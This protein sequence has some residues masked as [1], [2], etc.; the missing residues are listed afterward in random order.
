[1][2]EQKC[3]VCGDS[4]Q[5][6][7]PLSP[8]IGQ[9]CPQ[10]VEEF[11]AQEEPPQ[12]PKG[13]QGSKDE[14]DLPLP[15]RTNDELR[16]ELAVLQYCVRQLRERAKSDSTHAWL[17]K[18][19][20][21]VAVGCM[22]LIRTTLSEDIGSLPALSQEQQ[23]EI[24][25]EHPLLDNTRLPREPFCHEHSEWFREIRKKALDYA[26]RIDF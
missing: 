21:K 3:Q 2:N 5:G 6:K 19:K 1:M 25:R 11:D 15:G 4:F 26:R 17:W 18:L 20:A 14:V 23:D 16:G 24:Q 8:F 9:I 10:C 13:P 12:P 22:A 7:A